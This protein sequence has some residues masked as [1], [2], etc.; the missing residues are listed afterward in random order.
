MST[1]HDCG[2]S[3]KYLIPKLD[4]MGKNWTIWKFRVDMSLGAK[5]LKG[6]LNGKKRKSIDPASGHSP[7]W[8]PTT[9]AKI[10]AF[11]DYEKDL[12]EWE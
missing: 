7:A 8:I 11:E 3:N 5:G 12:E 6:H 2:E 1:N 9:P 10:K 4:A